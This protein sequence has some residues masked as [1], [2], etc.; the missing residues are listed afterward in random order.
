MLQKILI[1]INFNC[2]S[3]WSKTIFSMFRFVCFFLYYPLI[4]KI[5]SMHYLSRYHRYS[6][7]L[8]ILLQEPILRQKKLSPIKISAFLGC[9]LFVQTRLWLF[10]VVKLL[11]GY[12]QLSGWVHMSLRV[13]THGSL[14]GT[15]QRSLGQSCLM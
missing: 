12:L 14:R 8:L 7:T 11:M 9:V 15:C 4:Y 5:F 3:S 1:L 6:L 2:A 13:G 10:S